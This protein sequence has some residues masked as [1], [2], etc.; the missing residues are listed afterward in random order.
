[1]GNIKHKKSS[2]KSKV[3]KSEMMPHMSGKMMM[4]TKQM[5]KQARSMIKNKMM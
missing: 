1:M 2:V 4:T 5:E 3:I